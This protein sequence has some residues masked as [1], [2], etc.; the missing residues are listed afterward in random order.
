[1]RFAGFFAPS[2]RCFY[3]NN[4]FNDGDPAIGNLIA[5]GA[6]E[7]AEKGRDLRERLQNILSD[8]TLPT[9]PATLANYQSQIPFDGA[10]P[11]PDPL[12]MR[13]DRIDLRGCTYRTVASV[14]DATERN[15]IVTAFVAVPNL[16]LIVTPVSAQSLLI[17]TV[18]AFVHG[19]ANRATTS[20]QDHSG[21]IRVFN[22]TSAS[23]LPGAARAGIFDDSEGA[24]WL[25]FETR[26]TGLTGANTF[27]V[28]FA[29]NDLSFSPRLYLLG[30]IEPSRFSVIEHV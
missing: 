23:A 7:I 3:S 2:V 18:Q 6:A 21:L 17:F 11:T 24:W 4:N 19:T 14:T 10:T 25:N 28:E 1:M 15:T 27:N 26:V 22:V 16:Q 29:I 12:R 20:T 9:P 13:G 8:N 5:E 30:D